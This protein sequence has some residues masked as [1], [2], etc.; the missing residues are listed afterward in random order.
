MSTF[1]ADALRESAT[2]HSIDRVVNGSL[3][4][5]GVVSGTVLLQSIR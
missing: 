5:V 2:N 3:G 1:L 4:A